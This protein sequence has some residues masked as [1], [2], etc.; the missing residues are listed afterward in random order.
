MY[1]YLNKKMGRNKTIF[2]N[3]LS[4]ILV[5]GITFFTAPVFS[6]MLG[7]GNYGI[8]SVYNVWTGIIT[9]V[10]PLCVTS[11]QGMAV[12]E[13]PEEKQHEFQSGALS[14]G[15][16]S[17]FIFSTLVVLFL[18]PVETFFRMDRFLIITA[19]ISA[20][21][22]FVLNFANTKY[23]FEFKADINFIVSS[24]SLILSVLLSVLFITRM[25]PRVN[26]Y[27][28]ILGGV[29]ANAVTGMILLTLIYRDGRTFYHRDYWKFCL[30]L[31]V[32]VIFHALS[33]TELSQSDRIMIQSM[34]G[35]S[36]AGIYSL[37]YNFT[38]ILTTIYSALNDSW[39]PYFY[40]Y[41]SDGNAEGLKEH[42][43]QYI[44]LYTVICSGFL[45]LFPEVYKI[46]AGREYWEGV[47]FIPF[48]V[49]GCYAMFV[50]SFSVNFEF[51][52]KKTKFMAV[53]TSTAAALNLVLNYLFIS[54]LGL[55]GAAL[56]TAVSYVYEVAVHYVYAK[57]F[58]GAEY[59]FDR[60]FYL[61]HMGIFGILCILY[62]I[63]KSSMIVRW[64]IGI[65]SGLYIAA[66]MLKRKS[67]F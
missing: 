51:Y 38:A 4:V 61:K 37:A 13:F 27:G 54:S 9:I 58:C 52:C 47:S 19:L 28:R 50:Y 53:I 39:I 65:V 34:E 22:G 63:F 6:R 16:T 30:P 7:T 17:F 40:Q 59:P 1:V 44:E 33:N 55:M 56:A 10:F 15:I 24:A 42:A 8:V 62:F 60:M 32:P 66:K 49:A 11:V 31:S 46:F 35:N 14:L 3:V 41:L 48:I 26:Y 25:D 67:I 36:R 2:F 43:D 64:V 12:R 21:F 45:M 18:K 57:Y 29:A 23:M 5:K 20:F